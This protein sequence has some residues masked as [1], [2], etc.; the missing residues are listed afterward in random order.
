[1]LIEGLRP[2]V[3]NPKHKRTSLIWF[4]SVW[5]DSVVFQM[6]SSECQS[7]YQCDQVHQLYKVYMMKRFN[8]LTNVSE[9]DGLCMPLK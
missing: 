9:S 7:M 4:L 1:M 6:M 2:L 5:L 3:R 8:V